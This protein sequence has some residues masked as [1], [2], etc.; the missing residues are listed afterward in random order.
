M[1]LSITYLFAIQKYGYPPKPADDFKAIQD[2]AD[3][4][5]HHIEMEGL[6]SEHTAGV[7]ENRID[8]KKCLEDH[9]VRVHNFC[10]VDPA[11]V[12]LDPE[13][14]KSAYER[15]KRTAE[16]GV[17]L[18]AETL[19]IASYAPPLRYR[20]PK[21]YALGDT[22]TFADRLQAQVP[23]GFRWQTV[24]DALAESC[25]VTARIAADSGR[26]LIMEPRVG[27]VICSVD[28][29]L[30]LIEAVDEPNFKAN[31]DTG[32]FSAQ[33]E[34]IPLALMKLEGLY[35]NIHVSDNDPIDTKHRAIG[36]GTIDWQEFF[37]VLRLQRY[38]GYLGLDLGGSPTLAADLCRSADALSQLAA[39]QGIQ[40]TR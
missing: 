5:F 36:E 28:S 7:W 30:R 21:P 6:G 12:D 25:R 8:L 32:H 13:V 39:E 22:Y 26:T 18:G 37:R 4:G 23:D 15:F 14:R 27:E 2:V 1:K 33:R 34:L 11:L 17:E 9:G 10:A 16:L 35:A 19:H 40:L 31:F 29:M 38:D 24:W 3:L 20:G